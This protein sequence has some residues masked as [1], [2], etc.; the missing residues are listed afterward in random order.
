M[1]SRGRKSAVTYFCLLAVVVSASFSCQFHWDHGGERTS[2][3]VLLSRVTSE[4]LSLCHGDRHWEEY[5]WWN[6]SKPSDKVVSPVGKQLITVKD[7]ANFVVEQSGTTYCNLLFV[8]WV[9][10]PLHQKH[11]LEIQYCFQY[12][13]LS[14]ESHIPAKTLCPLM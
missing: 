9:T 5:I 6:F 11:I 10:V 14:G 4:Q 12:K 7:R 8:S 1:T 3:H 13:V 2:R